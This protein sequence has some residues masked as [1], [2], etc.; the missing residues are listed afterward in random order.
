VEKAELGFNKMSRAADEEEM[1][2]KRRRADELTRTE[3][4]NQS[5]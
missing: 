1:T 2:K 4:T 3:L 5:I